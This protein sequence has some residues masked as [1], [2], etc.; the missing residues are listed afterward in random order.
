MPGNMNHGARSQISKVQNQ[1]RATPGVD[2]SVRALARR[3]LERLPDYGFRISVMEWRDREQVVAHVAR[4]RQPESVEALLRGVALER[5]P[6]LGADGDTP[7]QCVCR[8][9]RLQLTF[10]DRKTSSPTYACYPKRTR[11][12]STSG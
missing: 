9:L 6:P 11:I 8:R 12:R 2:S 10:C 3:L 5:R 1:M 7:H 4:R